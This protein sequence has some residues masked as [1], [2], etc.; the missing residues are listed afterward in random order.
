LQAGR[1]RNRRL[2]TAAIALALGLVWSAAPAQSTTEKMKDKAE[3][4]KE[5][6]EEKATEFKSPL[7]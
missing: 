7:V 6:V 4:A 5:K 3:S 2:T 1:G